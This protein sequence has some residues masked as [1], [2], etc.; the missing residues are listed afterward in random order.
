MSYPVNTTENEFAIPAD[1]QFD[2]KKFIYKIIGVL[3][4]FIVSVVIC[5]ISFKNLSAIYN[6]G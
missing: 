3:P 6:A 4:W 1:N 5:I 2:V